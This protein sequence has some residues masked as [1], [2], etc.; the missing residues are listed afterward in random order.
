MDRIATTFSKIDITGEYSTMNR[1]ATALYLY[2][3]EN[4]QQWTEQL[5]HFQK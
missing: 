5:Q 3:Q 4:I 1:T 2:S